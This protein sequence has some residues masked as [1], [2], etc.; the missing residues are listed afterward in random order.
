MA[1]P[2]TTYGAMAA[3]MVIAGAVQTLSAQAQTA[4]PPPRDD[5]DPPTGTITG[6]RVSPPS[7]E[8][9]DR[10][11]GPALKRSQERREAPSSGD[12]DDTD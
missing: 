9:T 4:A 2:F 5:V 3:A 11:G 6:P 7:A 8:P 10:G 1:A 12:R